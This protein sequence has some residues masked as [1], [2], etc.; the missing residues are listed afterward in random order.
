MKKY[1]IG[2]F[3]IAQIFGFGGIGGYVLGDMVSRTPETTTD[4]NNLLTIT[5]GG[6]SNHLGGG[7]FLYLDVFF[8]SSI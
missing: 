6:I 5:P 3:L 2:L 4:A 8:H 1:F 7:G